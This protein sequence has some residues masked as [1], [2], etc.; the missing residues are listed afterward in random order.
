MRIP[1]MPSVTSPESATEEV[2]EE[3][4]DEPMPLE[5]ALEEVLEDEPMPSFRNLIRRSQGRK[6]VELVRTIFQLILQLTSQLITLQHITTHI[7][8]I[9]THYN[10]LQRITLQHITTYFLILLLIYTHVST[11][12]VSFNTARA[13]KIREAHL[14]G[15]HWWASDPSWLPHIVGMS[16]G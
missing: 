11:H 4:Q 6:V 2:L 15:S 10:A 9:T 3:V 5:E 1:E 7:P 12:S 16:P 13:A 14:N 8:H